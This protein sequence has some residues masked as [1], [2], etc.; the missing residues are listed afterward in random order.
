MF[1]HLDREAASRIGIANGHA[2]SVRALAFIMVGHAR[3]HL[4]VL[5][6]RYGVA[7]AA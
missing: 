1:V 4:A 7:G 2:I 6:S 3:H 5:G